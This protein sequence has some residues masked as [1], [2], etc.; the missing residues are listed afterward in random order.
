[1]GKL[2]AKGGSSG[3]K[4]RGGRETERETEH[5]VKG[6]ERRLK[7][8]EGGETG[9]RGKTASQAGPDHRGPCSKTQEFGLQS[10]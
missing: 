8:R 4:L 7:H 6:A 2:Q 9:R 1:M 5:L 3:E 10:W